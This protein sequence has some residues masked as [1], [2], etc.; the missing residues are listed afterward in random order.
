[1]YGHDYTLWAKEELQ[2]LRGKA[3]IG[4]KILSDL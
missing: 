4:V 1:M 3:D 2:S